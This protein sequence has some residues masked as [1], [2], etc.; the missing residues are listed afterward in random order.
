M[1]IFLQGSEISSARLVENHLNVRIIWKFTGGHILEKHRSSKL[2]VL[3]SGLIVAHFNTL[4]I[5]WKF[6]IIVIWI[7]KV[8]A[9]TSYPK[10]STW[11]PLLFSLVLPPS[12]SSLR[13]EICGYQCRQRA[14]LNWHMKK[15][16]PEAHYNFTCEFCNKRF[17]KL[18]S[19]K[20]HK[21][22]SHPEKQA[23]W[24]VLTLLPEPVQVGHQRLKGDFQKRER[25]SIAVFVTPV[26]SRLM[27]LA[28]TRGRRWTGL[29]A[30]W[31]TSR[32]RAEVWSSK[33]E[34]GF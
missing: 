23:T 26:M 16:T 1:C 8:D 6:V 33:E 18:D 25:H 15:H 4:H 5:A 29:T 30:V 19:V 34:T 9:C 3:L 7:C 2:P 21:L 31:D 27:W 10:E 12:S 28:F 17:E 14:S 13:C 32:A 11:L 24:T 20:F 22:K